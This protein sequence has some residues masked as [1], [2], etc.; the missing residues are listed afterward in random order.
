MAIE[1]ATKYL[2]YVDEIFTTESRKSLITNTDFDFVNA[3]TVKI[4]TVGIAD[5]HDYGRNGAATGN[6]SRYGEVQ[7]LDATTQAMQLTKDRSFTFAIDKLDTDETVNALN[8][9][10]ALSR[11]IRQIVV[12]E[13]DAWTVEQMIAGAGNVPAAT[14]LTAANIYGAIVDGSNALDTA[15]A[16]DTGR[17]LMVTPK[18]YLLMKKS[19]E[20]IMET[21]IGAN[22]RIRGVISNLDGM[23]VMKIP[24]ARVPDDFG[25]MIAHPV[26]TVAPSKLNDYTVHANPPG[27]SGSLVEGRV[28]YDAFVLNNKKEA[29]YYQAVT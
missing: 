22:M 7:E 21:D 19:K 18:T 4:Y 14:G 12:P 16:P 6:W 20:I 1:L 5:M 2:G 8:A 9:A 26:A 13:V 27:I 25:F 24:A 3:N 28:V 10:S 17:V 23:Q 11:Q 15:E 29:I